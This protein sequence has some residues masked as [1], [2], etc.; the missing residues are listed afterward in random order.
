MTGTHNHLRAHS[1]KTFDFQ[2]LPSSSNVKPH[3]FPSVCWKKCRAVN[4]N[5]FHLKERIALGRP[6]IQ[7]EINWRIT[8][9]VERGPPGFRGPAPRPLRRGERC[10]RAILHGVVGPFEE[11]HEHAPHVQACQVGQ[12][13]FAQMIFWTVTLAVSHCRPGASWTR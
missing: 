3:V 5:T 7:N 12:E 4:K 8:R 10:P 6:Q 11:R 1:H 2:D 13:L 9:E